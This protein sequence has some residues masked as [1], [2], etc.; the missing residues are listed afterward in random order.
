MLP[1]AALEPQRLA[2]NGVGAL[3]PNIGAGMVSAAVAFVGIRKPGVDAGGA[4]E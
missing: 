1:N 3:A 4:V 2:F